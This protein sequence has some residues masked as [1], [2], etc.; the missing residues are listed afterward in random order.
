MDRW[1]NKE[2]QC[3]AESLSLEPEEATGYDIAQ[4]F[5]SRKVRV[6]S[7]HVRCSFSFAE[8]AGFLQLLNFAIMEARIGCSF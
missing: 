1:N 5:C 3:S 7:R 2:K 8:I 6:V 4:F